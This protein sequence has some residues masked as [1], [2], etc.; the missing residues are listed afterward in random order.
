M[1]KL[2]E[3]TINNGDRRLKDIIVNGERLV[4][5]ETGILYNFI[6][7]YFRH[8]FA[9][10]SGLNTVVQSPNKHLQPNI[11]TRQSSVFVRGDLK[12]Q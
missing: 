9:R 2:L 8:Y 12:S 10:Y 4:D 5:H 1:C 7:V 3:H 6:L 11:S